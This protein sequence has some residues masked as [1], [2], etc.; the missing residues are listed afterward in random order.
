MSSYATTTMFGLIKNLG[1]KPGAAEP[2]FGFIKGDDT[3]DRFFLPGSMVQ[4]VGCD[5]SELCVG[6]RVSFEHEDNAR[7]PRAVRVRLMAS[8]S[9]AAA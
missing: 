8:S 6:Q 7:G 5:F 4:P 9:Q 1:K 2:T 3:V